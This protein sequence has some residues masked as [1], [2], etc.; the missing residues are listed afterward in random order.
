MHRPDVAFVVKLW[1]HLAAQ[2]ASDFRVFEKD[3]SLKAGVGGEHFR[4]LRALDVLLTVPLRHVVG[5]VT[6]AD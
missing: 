5:H 2:L 6:L 3:V 4:A 1:K